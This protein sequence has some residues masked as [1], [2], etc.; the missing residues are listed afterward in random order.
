MHTALLF[1]LLAALPI[2]AHAQA[3]TGLPCAPTD[4]DCM[5]RAIRAHPMHSLDSWQAVMNRPLVERVEAA[6]DSLVQYLTMDNILN[7][8]PERPRAM[9]PNPRFVADVKAALADLPTE[10]NLLFVD[11]LVGIFL[12][13]D[14]G[15]TGFTDFV[16]DASGQP[17][18]GLIVLDAK[19]LDRFTANEW[20][21]WKE[22]T[23]F[24]PD[25]AWR[26]EARIATAAQDNR[27]NAIQY[28]LLHELGH[29][30]SIGGNVHPP[31]TQQPRDVAAAE[32]YPFFNLSWRVDAGE[33]RFATRFDSEFPQRTNVN[34]YFGAKLAG[35]AMGVTYSNLMKTNFPSL[36]AATRPGDDFA[37]AFA[38][39]V[40]VVLMERL[41]EIT[42]TRGGEVVQV[43]KACWE[44]P[45]CADKRKLLED[46]AGRRRP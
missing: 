19:V 24:K 38:S 42:V 26:L 12:V 14:L 30:L 41:W 28:I 16:N 31:W 25:P 18:A 32:A 15:G 13:E 9:A 35:A 43:F 45:R 4:R 20:A 7:G 10:V 34:Y 44:E 33:N 22:N 29:V 37:E 2:A 46:L 27:R 17:V 21:T 39:Y 1:G 6:Q 23:P 36:Y 11:K 3:A 8:Y 40:H 5:V